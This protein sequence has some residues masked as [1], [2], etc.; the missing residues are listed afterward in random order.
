MIDKADISRLDVRSLRVFLAVYQ[1]N[2]I[3]KAA[4]K[5]GLNQST[6]SHCVDRLRIAFDDQ[7]FLRS[8]RG[9]S[10][11]ARQRFWAHC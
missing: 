3:S 4:D 2:S 11:S 6:I 9:I 5:F 8:G 1:L 7:L 10:P